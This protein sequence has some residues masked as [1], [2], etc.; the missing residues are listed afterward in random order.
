MIK[1]LRNPA[2]LFCLSAALLLSLAAVITG[3]GSGAAP[4]FESD[5]D[6]TPAEQ[7]LGERIFIDTRFAEYF[8]E[9]MTGVNDPLTTGDPVVAQVQNVYVGP[10]PGPFA[11]QSINC[12]SCH[13]VVEF[14]GV[15]GFGNRTYA[16]FT[17]RS[18]IP[19]AMNGFTNT[20]RNA[21]QMVGSLQHPGTT[22]LHFDGQ[23]VDPADL[24]KTTMTGRNFGWA[25]TQYSQAIAHIAQVIRQDNGNNTPSQTYTDGYSYAAIFLGS[26][27]LPAQD[28]IAPHYRV[29]VSTATDDQVVNA[30]AAVVAAYAQGL[31]FKQDEFSRYIGSPYDVFLRV[32]HLPVQPKAG[33]TVGAYNQRLYQAVSALSNPTFVTPADG[34]FKYHS[35]PFQFGATELQGLLIFLRTAT[36]PTDG[37]QHAGN[38]ASCHQ[39]PYFSD[40][41][42]HNNGAAQ[43]EYDGVH[44]SGAFSQL[45][46]PSLSQRNA[47]YNAW[48]PVTA[49]HPN[50]SETFRRAATLD[51][52]NYADLGLW[53]IYLNPDIPNPQAALQSFLCANSANCATDQG[54]GNT[55]ALFKTPILRDLQDSAPYFHNGSK[56][57]FQDV[58]NFYITT[59]ALARNGQVRNGDPQLK[60]ISINS[61]D[62]AALVAFLQSLTE[63]YDD[64]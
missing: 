8:A 34:S 51:N 38:C 35:Q 53:N 19:L 44:G 40:F 21:M 2:S 13:F 23:F 52:P 22:F 20:P 37:S 17:N 9:H 47:N 60:N 50:A 11:G 61:N 43:E 49:A 27:S 29:D 56:L 57:M 1:T 12:R 16:D 58:V 54:L 42:F 63:D 59:S 33:E 64:A 39:A 26:S 3:C 41:V 10:L 25:P 62:I 14:Q 4:P 28:Q 5:I 48:L 7:N 24:V 46:I 15:K 45:F 31:Q 36:N 30:V 55:V 32:N 6:T 18:P